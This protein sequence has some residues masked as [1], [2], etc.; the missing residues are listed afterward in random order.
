LWDGGSR[1]TWTGIQLGTGKLVSLPICGFMKI[2]PDYVPTPGVAVIRHQ[3]SC[4]KDVGC[5]VW[6]HP[7]DAEKFG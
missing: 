5:T 7:A 4:G 1:D 3:I 2:E 6:I